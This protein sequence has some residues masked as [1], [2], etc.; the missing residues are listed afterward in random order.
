MPV[1]IRCEVD[2][3]ETEYYISS[4]NSRMKHCKICHAK[5]SNN[6]KKKKRL[7][8][9]EQAEKIRQYNRNNFHNRRGAA[10]TH[11]IEETAICKEYFSNKCMYCDSIDNI[12]EDHI[13]ALSAGGTNYINNIG[14][15][16]LSCNCSK[17]QDDMETWFKKQIFF[18]EE[19]LN[20]IISWRCK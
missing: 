11:T 12:T 19:K 6:W 15:A 3:P 17:K 18:S 20:K 5:Y 9:G 14:L 2:K 10:G 13:Q 8:N 7:E 1:C 16:C 4:S